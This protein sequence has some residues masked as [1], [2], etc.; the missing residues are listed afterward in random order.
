MHI[1][2][3]GDLLIL[4]ACLL[5]HFAHC[6]QH[7]GQEARVEMTLGHFEVFEGGLTFLAGPSEAAWQVHRALNLR[8]VRLF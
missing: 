5:L 2:G 4:S 7:G 1:G 3:F 6:L 8:N